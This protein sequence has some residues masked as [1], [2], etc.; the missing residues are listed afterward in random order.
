MENSTI[1]PTKLRSLKLI[2]EQKLK[3]RVPLTDLSH[4]ISNISDELCMIK[5]RKDLTF[6]EA[7]QQLDQLNSVK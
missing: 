1:L 7:K 3:T 4:S 5:N 6:E 2:R